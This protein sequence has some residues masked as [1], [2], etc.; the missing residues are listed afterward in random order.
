M[1]ERQSARCSRTSVAGSEWSVPSTN[2]ASVSGSVCPVMRCCLSFQ[3][4]AQLPDDPIRDAVDPTRTVQP[5]LAGDL[6]RRPSP[7]ESKLKQVALAR[8]E[9]P[10]HR[11]DAFRRRTGLALHQVVLGAEGRGIMVELFAH[12]IEVFEHPPRRRADRLGVQVVREAFQPGVAETILDAA[13][14]GGE[15][16]DRPDFAVPKLLD[17]LARRSTLEIMK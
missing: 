8:L 3:P 13:Q 7:L 2:S 12:M 11:V 14:A 6:P 10:D 9:R 17:D 5:K 15:A 1:H 16:I 4:A